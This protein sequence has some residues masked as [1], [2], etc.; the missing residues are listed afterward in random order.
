GWL[1][2]L[3]AGGF[4]TAIDPERSLY[5]RLDSDMDDEG[6]GPARGKDW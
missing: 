2:L 4:C 1:L 3:E 6:E 5:A